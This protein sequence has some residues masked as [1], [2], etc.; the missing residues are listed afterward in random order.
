ML[1]VMCFPTILFHQPVPEWGE[2][3]KCW[4]IPYQ[5]YIIYLNPSISVSGEWEWLVMVYIRGS[6]N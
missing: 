3:V 1:K 4:C 5:P 2:V 6:S